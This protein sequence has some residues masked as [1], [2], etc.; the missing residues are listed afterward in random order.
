MS[1]LKY[2]SLIIPVGKQ[3]LLADYTSILKNLNQVKMLGEIKN[4]DFK[5]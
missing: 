4:E 1:D 5:V 3:W 2:S